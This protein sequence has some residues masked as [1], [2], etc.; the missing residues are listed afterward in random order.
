MIAAYLAGA[1]A[2]EAAAPFGYSGDA[3]R[4]VLSRNG[5]AARS[6]QITKE[7]EEGM[8]AAYLDGATQKQAAALFGHPAAAALK[9]CGAIIFQREVYKYH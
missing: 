6:Q 9:P 7:H 4:K 1:S 8:I 5:I 2:K 3:C